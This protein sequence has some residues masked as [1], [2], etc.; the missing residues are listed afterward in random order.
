MLCTHV[1]DRVNADAFSARKPAKEMQASCPYK[2]DQ[3]A[4]IRLCARCIAEDAE[5]AA[6]L[7]RRQRAA[8][9]ILGNA[10]QDDVE[11]TRHRA[12]ESSC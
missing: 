11:P 4:P 7:E 1:I 9:A 12:R 3:P 2:K 10:V 8:T 6:R 5:Q